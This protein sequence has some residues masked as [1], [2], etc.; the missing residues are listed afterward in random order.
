MLRVRDHARHGDHTTQSTARP[1]HALAAGEGERIW[2]V[3]D[4]MTLKATAETTGGKP[5]C[6]SRT[7]P[8]PAAAPRRTSTP[9]RT[10]SSTS[11]TA[12]FE[13]RIGD[14]LHAVGPGGFAYVPRG[15]VH[16][17]RNTAETPEPHPRRLHARRHGGL[18]PRVGAPGDRRRPRAAG[19]RGRDRPHHGRRTEVRRRGRGLRLDRGLRAR[20]GMRRAQRGQDRARCR[21]AVQGVEVHSGRA[22]RQEIGALEGRVSDPELC[23]RFRV[24]GAP[25]RARRSR[26]SG[27]VAPHMSVKRLIWP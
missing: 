2:I 27:I 16:N 15:T 1:A 3:G 5:R 24:V 8:R 23:N 14:E 11:S 20:P 22:S 25:V 12:R 10:S 9:A 19:G 7:S 21:R 4:T 13:V 6:C 17:F 18:L 26:S